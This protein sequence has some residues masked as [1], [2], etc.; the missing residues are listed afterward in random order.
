ME[1][2]IWGVRLVYG[3]VH[4]GSR[5]VYMVCM[6]GIYMGSQVGVRGG[7]YAEWCG[8]AGWFTRSVEWA[9]SRAV[10][11]KGWEGSY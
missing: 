11:R 1:R 8:C 3:A 7:L 4:M 9:C 5:W 10:N 2:F 6:V